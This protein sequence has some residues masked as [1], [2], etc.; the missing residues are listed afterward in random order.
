MKRSTEIRVC[1]LKSGQADT[2]LLYLYFENKQFFW[3]NASPVS[4]VYTILRVQELDTFLHF[5]RFSSDKNKSTLFK[6]A[7]VFYNHIITRNFYN[8]L[9]TEQM[10]TVNSVKCCPLSISIFPILSTFMNKL[11]QMAEGVD[12]DGDCLKKATFLSVTTFCLCLLSQL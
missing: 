6:L 3:R 8:F 2:L 12:D 1:P 5:S 11:Q 9:L 7:L 4:N 10:A